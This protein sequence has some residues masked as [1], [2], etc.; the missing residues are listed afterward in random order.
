VSTDGEIPF[1]GPSRYRA[2]R[3]FDSRYQDTLREIAAGDGPSPR[4]SSWPAVASR[5]VSALGH[6]S[7]L[8][9]TDE[10]YTAELTS[11][12]RGQVSDRLQPPGRP[13]RQKRSPVAAGNVILLWGATPNS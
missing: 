9:P 4:V 8:V 1:Y 12:K 7:H 13:R 10:A 6:L 3:L 2:A 11:L 5:Y